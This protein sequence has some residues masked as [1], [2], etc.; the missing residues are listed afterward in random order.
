LQRFRSTA[1]PDNGSRQSRFPFADSFGM[2]QASIL[3]H[4]ID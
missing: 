3:F 1:L 2:A 4:E